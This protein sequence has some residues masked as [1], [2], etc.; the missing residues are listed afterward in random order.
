[1][2][3]VWEHLGDWETASRVCK[4]V[5]NFPN[6]LVVRWGY[7]NTEKV[8]LLLKPVSVIDLLAIKSNKD[9]VY[10]FF[11]HWTT[12][13]TSKQYIKRR[14]IQKNVCRES[15]RK[16]CHVILMYVYLPSISSLSKC[17]PVQGRTQIEHLSIRLKQ[18]Q[19]EIYYKGVF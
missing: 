15:K 12:I 2:V 17:R 19:V 18:P 1:M 6:S 8:A 9:K 14:I 10:V 11:S 5:S 7:V 3:P 13:S 4:T 16:G